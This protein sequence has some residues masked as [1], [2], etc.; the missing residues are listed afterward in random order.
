MSSERK[1][2][3]V[4]VPSE[5]EDRPRLARVG[6]VA[7]VCFVVGVVWP[8]LAGVR[9]VPDP[10]TK[11]S[12]E[13]PDKAT[14]RPAR[15]LTEDST[16][17][18]PVQKVEA[19]AAL[20]KPGVQVGDVL[21]VNCR[22]AEERRL[23]QCDKPDFDGVAKDRLMALLGCEAAGQPKGLLSVG[24]DLD[25]RAKKIQRIMRGK[26]TTLDDATADAL[27]ACAKQE[28]MSAT[29][30]GVTHTHA[31]YLLFYSVDFSPSQGQ[32]VDVGEPIVE[33]SGKATIIW[34][35]ARLRDRPDDGEVK[36]T[37]MYGAEVFVSGRQGDWYRVKYDAKGNEA[38]VHKNALAL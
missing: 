5:Q 30:E 28:F 32:P 15:S 10:P 13:A 1:N 7:A 21:V 29:L 37:L 2:P 27:V 38:W 11:K 14:P 33:T 16:A 8:T 12:D 3:H 17:E 22:D 31:H 18:V 25:F 36:A 26:S 20:E 24:F 6:I 9:L 4:I 23:N 19:Q 34:N 35:S